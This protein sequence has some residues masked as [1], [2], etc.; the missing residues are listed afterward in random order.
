MVEKKC[1]AVIPARGGSKRI[2]GKNIVDFHGRPLLYWTIEAARQSG[3]FDRILVSTDDPA[4]ASA[5]ERCGLEVPFLRDRCA[6][7]QATASSATIAALAQV[8]TILHETYAIVVQLM[9][10]CPLRKGNHITQAYANF[11]RRRARFQI[12]CTTFGPTNPWWAAKLDELMQ[13]S[14]LFPDA[15]V[16]RSQDLPPLYCP[17]GAIWI[18]GTDALKNAGTFYGPGHIYFPMPW[19]AALDIDEPADLELARAL[20]SSS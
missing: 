18:A 2:P 11:T 5:A 17:T 3:L 1:I 4:I 20:F 16:S 19:T 7:D 6:D 14:S 12:S 9:P 13:P 15:L 8:E 10:T